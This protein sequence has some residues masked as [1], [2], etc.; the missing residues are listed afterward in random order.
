MTRAIAS[1]FYPKITEG[2]LRGAI[3]ELKKRKLHY[4]IFKVNKEKI[5]NKL[6]KNL[7]INLDY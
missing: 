4:D 1:T 6:K 5:L 7:L 3:S 2:L